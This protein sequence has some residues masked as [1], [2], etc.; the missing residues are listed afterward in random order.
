MLPGLLCLALALGLSGCSDEPQVAELKAYARQIHGFRPFDERV[1]QTIARLDD[2]TW[3]VT[4]ADIEAARTLLD[5][6][7]A[8]VAAVPDPDEAALRD[9]HGVYGRA[10]EEARRR[11]RDGTG[12]T[13][14]RA[15][16]VAI[17]LHDLRR[18]VEGRVYPSL[19]VLLAR[20]NLG[21]GGYELSW[22]ARP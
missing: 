2:P 11:A 4:D 15:H 13:R 21:G 17:A 20:A 9:T 14:H 3:A 7:A 5:E 8:A 10:V 6:Y 12:D 1:E 22:P 18:D 19:D 16:A